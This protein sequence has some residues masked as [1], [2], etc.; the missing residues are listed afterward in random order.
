LGDSTAAGIREVTVPTITGIVADQQTPSDTLIDPFATVTINDPNV[1]ATDTLTI[2]LT[3]DGMTG[4]LSGIG[5]TDNTD[6]VYTLS[7]TA[8]DITEDLH[9][10]SFDPTGGAGT[11]TIFALSDVSSGDPSSPATNDATTVNQTAPL[12]TTDSILFQSTD[13]QAGI[14][15]LNGTNVTGGGTVGP[16][17]GPSWKIIGTGDFFGNGL[18]DILWQNTDGQAAIWELNGTNIIG[19]VAV[20][21]NPGSAWKAVGTGDFFDDGNSDILWQNTDGQA[22]VW[23]VKNTLISG[24]AVTPNPGP[25]WKAIGTGDFNDDGHSDILWQN[26]DGQSAIWEM[27]GTNIIGGGAVNSNAGPSWKAA[28]L[29]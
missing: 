27:S 13:G 26:T 1:G 24:G 9:G 25:S 19:G 7:G 4:Q 15:E 10:L 22:A 29:T 20:I 28:G 23:N 16:E 2:T 14:W 3:G 8:F 21:P 6:G 17:L 11:A 18:S 5:L 12:I